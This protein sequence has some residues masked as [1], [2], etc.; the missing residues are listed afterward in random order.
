VTESPRAL[1]LWIYRLAR[2]GL[3]GIFLWSGLLKA[4]DAPG[5]AQVVGAWGV[6]PD[7]LSLPVA[8]ALPVL[9]V[10][11]G[12]ALA[13]DLQGGLE[14]VAAMLLGFCAL[15]AYGIFSG[16]DVPCGCF[17]DDEGGLAG[18]R[19]ALLRDLVFLAAVG[20]LYLLRWKAGLRAQGWG[21][22]FRG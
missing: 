9:E 17:G 12:A 16:M 14:L 5:F 6:L 8:I 22:V 2:W 4:L 7:A 13:L 3:A 20:L 11:A 19:T 10:A 1:P 18:L 15:L 21:R